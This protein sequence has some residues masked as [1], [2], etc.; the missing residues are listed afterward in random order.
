MDL[1]LTFYANR[2]LL[3]VNPDGIRVEVR[4]GSVHR[5]LAFNA[6]TSLSIKLPVQRREEVLEIFVHG[7]PATAPGD[8]RKLFIF[9]QDVQWSC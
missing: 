2:A 8:L 7:R 1:H 3:A 9:L 4:T 6:E 5:K